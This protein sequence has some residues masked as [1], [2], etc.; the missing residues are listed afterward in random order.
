M[1][2]LLAVALTLL[3]GCVA[4]PDYRRPAATPTVPPAYAGW[5]IA[6]PKA[7]QPKGNWWEMFG[8][9]ELNRLEAAAAAANQELKAA[10]AGFEQARASADITRADLFPNLILAPTA[11]R[12]RDSNNRPVN[13]V[14]GGPIPLYNTLTVPLTAGY[15][16]D[17]WGRVRRSVESA[18]AQVQASADDLESVKLAIQAEVAT[19][20]F[21]LRALD[22]ELMLL[23]S[24][25]TEFRKALELT[26]HR[27]QGGVASDLDVAQAETVLKTTEAQVPAMALQRA[28][29]E[30]GLALLT[31][32][33]A[34]A[35]AL[36]EQPLQSVSPTIPP[37]LP[38]ELLERRP[39]IAAA[40]RR[41]AAANAQIGVAQAAFF[42][43]LRFNGLAGLQSLDA[44]TLFN[45]PSRLWAVGPSLS[46]PLFEGGARSA[47]VRQRRSAYD[48][49]VALYRQT[50]LAAFA[51]VEDHLAAQTLLTAQYEQET[52][53]LGA[54]RKQLEIATNRYRSGLVTYLEVS[55]AQNLV[56][57]EERTVIGL[58][59]ARLVTTVALV[60]SLGGGWSD[61]GRS[62]SAPGR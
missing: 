17:L 32:R 40:E 11:T 36:A 2:R 53:A 50:T 41:M 3:A 23:R 61:Q 30:H 55:L 33:P 8:D 60:K 48:Q 4:G 42:P 54:A 26:R 47:T 22:A 58:H 52:A 1:K 7:D 34:P 43:T 14:A 5:K 51:E 25:V 37:G 44:D 45:W 10:V 20:Y 18:R 39:D 21:T 28:R 24:S 57:Q 49:M 59:G 15:E 27:R 46:L 9:P 62:K 56:L 19:D 16:L 38:S 31:G 12:E 6:E 29:F 35:F 13:G